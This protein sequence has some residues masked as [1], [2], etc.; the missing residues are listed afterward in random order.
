MKPESVTIAAAVAEAEAAH[1]A[2]QA[3][4]AAAALAAE[5]N[6]DGSAA[7]L[8]T[9]EKHAGQAAAALRH[10]R[11][12]GGEL[13]R[14]TDAKREAADRAAKL[15][16]LDEYE[17]ARDF[18]RDASRKLFEQVADLEPLVR[19]ARERAKAAR[20]LASALGLPVIGGGAFHPELVAS[21]DAFAAVMGDV[22]DARPRMLDAARA[23]VSK[24]WRDTIEGQRARELRAA[25]GGQGKA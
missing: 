11:L 1:E 16:L 18:V 17:V 19:E 6:A 21:R 2:A 24:D 9:A 3:E 15:A 7:K 5:R 23:K 14:E 13:E 10:A 4:V 20:L 25:L 8:A 22:G 12:A